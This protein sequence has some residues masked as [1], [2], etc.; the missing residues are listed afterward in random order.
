MLDIYNKVDSVY[1]RDLKILIIMYNYGKYKIVV[2]IEILLIKDKNYV[3]NN[4]V[5]IMTW[6][7]DLSYINIIYKSI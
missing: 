5:D 7:R 2:K 3:K 6:S 1:N 4:N